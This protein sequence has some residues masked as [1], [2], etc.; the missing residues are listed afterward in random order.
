MVLPGQ[1]IRLILVFS[2]VSRVEL[3]CAP[4]NANYVY[5]LIEANQ[6]C[7]AFI[8]SNNKASSFTSM[9]E[10]NDADG[11]IPATD[12]TRNQAWYNLILAVDPNDEDVVIAG[13]N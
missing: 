2:G 6:I 11:G 8:Y 10:P 12:F 3:A 13:R 4:S 5:G 7:H 9:S 1:P